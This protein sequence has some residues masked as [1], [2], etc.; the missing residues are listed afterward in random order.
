[1][2]LLLELVTHMDAGDRA[3]WAGD[4]DERPLSD[5]GQRQAARLA[6]ALALARIDALFCSPAL[7]CR[8]TVQPLA[9]RLGLPIQNLPELHE[10]HGFA[11]PPG[12]DAPFWSAIHAPLGG[13]YAAGRALAAMRRIARSR[14]DGRAVACAHG[15]IIPVFIACLTGI[16]A[17]PPVAPLTQRGGWYTI[18]LDD[19]VRVTAHLAPDGFPG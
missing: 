19:D 13:A 10:T 9:D 8:Q 5:P 6:S 12:W 7:R 16:H 3:T 14:P 1:M 15:D 18:A 2:T 4:Q 17:L 11:P